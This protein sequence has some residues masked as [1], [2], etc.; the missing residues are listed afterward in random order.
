MKVGSVPGED[1]KTQVRRPDSHKATLP[2]RGCKL[3]PL[4]TMGH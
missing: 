4:T 1:A 2:I 3:Y